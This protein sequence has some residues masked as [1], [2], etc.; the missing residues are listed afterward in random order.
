MGLYKR[1]ATY[2][3][4]N[5]KPED[6]DLAALLNYMTKHHLNSIE[7]VQEHKF[8]KVIP[9]GKHEGTDVSFILKEDKQYINWILNQD[10]F[11]SKYSILYNNIKTEF[12]KSQAQMDLF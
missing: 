3:Q 4:H 5:E 8:N 12:A 6:E 11:K 9:F 2:E 7:E 1:L 10:W